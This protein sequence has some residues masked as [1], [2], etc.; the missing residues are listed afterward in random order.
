MIKYLCFIFL[1]LPISV[2]AHFEFSVNT[3]K[4]NDAIINLRLDE[5]LRLIEHEKRIN[6][7][8]KYT[9]ALEHKL[10]FIKAFLS[11]ESGDISIF[12]SLR[13]KALESI[14]KGNVNSPYFLFCQA[15]I[16]IQSAVIKFK[17]REFIS[18]ALEINKAYRLLERNQAMFPDFTPNLKGL[19]LLHTILGAVPEDYKWAIKLAGM[20]GSVTKG[21]IELKLFK[22]ATYKD[23]SLYFMR[24]EAIFLE[25]AIEIHFGSG[26]KNTSRLVFDIENKPLL[27]FIAA[28]SAMHLGKN[29]EAYELL[30]KLPENKEYNKIHY[31]D[32]MRG[33]ILL[34]NL[35]LRAEG[36]FQQF[37]THFKGENFIRACY[38][39]LAW[40]ALIKGESDIY[41]QQI[42]KCNFQGSD[43]TDE[44]KL[45]TKEYRTGEMPDVN[46]LKCRLLFD[47]GYFV[48]A[49]EII[50]ALKFEEFKTRKHQLEYY[51]RKARINH[52]LGNIDLALKQYEEVI[53]Y[54][55]NDKSY[56]GANSALQKAL[57][58]EEQGK[59]NLAK[60]YFRK[61]L[62][63]R[64]SE[65]RNSLDQKAKAG[66]A[67][68]QSASV[69]NLKTPSKG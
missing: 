15:D 64:K 47:G 61:C 45:A 13:D 17:S 14:Q 22:L 28:S 10:F 5:G 23:S 62:T 49:M 32:Y 21:I 3:L 11:E 68:I 46:L 56:F 37:L 1:L 50:S 2:Y 31:A 39:K 60:E 42:S 29:N 66:L 6:P 63:M 48:E 35:D 4:A 43:L 52:M 12:K 18:A 51:Y 33:I 8:N 67:R 16:L 34:S 57:I 41:Y 38:Q 9:F 30:K 36:H 55:I 25:K 69:N 59:N 58:F 44:D 53:T 7:G 26:K 27:I 54:G 24:T 65:Y 19:G 40:I 20:E